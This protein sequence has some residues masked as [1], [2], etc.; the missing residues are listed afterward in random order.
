MIELFQMFR[1]HDRLTI[2]FTCIVNSLHSAHMDSIL[3]LLFLSKTG[4]QP[5]LTLQ[6]SHTIA[7]T[8]SQ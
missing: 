1:I 2:A 7:D 3:N 6:A 8:N 4:K 5:S